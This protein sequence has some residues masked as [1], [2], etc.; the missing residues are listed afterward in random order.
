[1]EYFKKQVFSKNQSK[2][3]LVQ[4]GDFA[5]SPIHIDEGSVALLEK[6]EEGYVSPLYTIFQ[7]IDSEINK[8]FLHYLMKSQRF[9]YIF[10][11][12]GEGTLERRRS[13]KVKDMKKLFFPFPSKIEQ[14][15]IVSLLENLELNILN[16][17]DIIQHRLDYKNG[18]REEIF[19]KGLNH[20]KPKK[21]DWY[22]NKQLSIPSDWDVLSGEEIIRDTQLGL[23]PDNNLESKDIALIKMGNLTFGNFDLDNI[24]CISKNQ[25][26]LESYMLKNNDF[27]FNTRNSEYLVGKSAVWKL[28]LEKAVFNNNLMRIWFHENIIPNP[29]FVSNYLSSH[30]GRRVL[31]RFSEKTVGVAAIYLHSLKEM[32]F[33]VPKPE[34]QKYIISILLNIDALIEKEKIHK[35][36][37]ERL[38]KGLIQKLLTGQ[39]RVQ[40]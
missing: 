33:L 26:D 30:V 1:M 5:Y 16:S 24:E 8:K 9:L 4:K 25:D 28:N 31:R 27:L 22:F 36:N 14:D 29:E 11:A 23:N 3:K 35:L 17:T 38:K 12:M 7:V 6:Y 19:S 15:R 21:I 32:K 40:V 39:I 37:L 2:Y 20:K 34:E 10:S 18:I 13:V